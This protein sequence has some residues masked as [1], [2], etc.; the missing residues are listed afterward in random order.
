MGC[1]TSKS[2]SDIEAAASAAQLFVNGAR[3]LA[4]RV[5]ALPPGYV[6]TRLGAPSGDDG[7]VVAQAS[8][9]SIEAAAYDTAF[10]G[11]AAWGVALESAFVESHPGVGCTVYDACVDVPNAQLPAGTPAAVKLVKQA[12][13]DGSTD[14]LF[15]DAAL[16]ACNSAFVKLDLEGAEYRLLPKMFARGDLQKIRQLVIEIHGAEDIRLHPAYYAKMSGVTSAEATLGHQFAILDLVMKTHALVH[17]HA[18]NACTTHMV[19][20]QTLPSVFECTFLRKADFPKHKWINSTRALPDM[21][22]D[23]ANVVGKP[24]MSLGA[25][26]SASA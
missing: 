12:L 7:W 3:L 15:A 19:A 20:G 4:L 22:V 25:P 13:G 2:V 9:A 16:A 1:A 21:A 14:T 10:S 8:D 23:S 18:N 11:G 6:L 24:Q 26:F 17:V 5:K